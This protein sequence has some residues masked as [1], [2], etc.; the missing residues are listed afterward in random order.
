MFQ[1]T[2]NRPFI[3]DKGRILHEFMLGVDYTTKNKF[4]PSGIM[5][6][7]TYGYRFVD[8]VKK[9]YFFMLGTSVGYNFQLS[10]GF[11]NQIKIGPFAY[12]ELL[13]FLNI[14]AGYEYSTQ[15][16]KGYPFISIG[17]GGL[18]MLR[19]FKIGF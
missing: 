8:N 15:I 6:Q 16:Q 3:Y 2:L 4:A 18:H 17:F 10:S 14:K 7:A 1:A 12:L 11:E 5:L 19:H 13:A 9:E